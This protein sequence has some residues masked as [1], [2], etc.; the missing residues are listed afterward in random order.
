VISG[1]KRDY[2][3]VLESWTIP[4]AETDS[5][6]GYT[7]PFAHLREMGFNTLD[8]SIAESDA[9]SNAIEHAFAGDDDNL[10]TWDLIGNI[11]RKSQ[12]SEE[13]IQR[14]PGQQ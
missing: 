3:S 5:T 8:H 7:L 12:A 6:S 9:G 1:L 14:L 10:A 2:L 11:R 13:L 4:L